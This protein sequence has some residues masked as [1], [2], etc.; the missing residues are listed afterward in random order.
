MQHLQS[1]NPQLALALGKVQE[2]ELRRAGQQAQAEQKVLE[3]LHTTV[4]EAPLDKIFPQ[5]KVQDAR[6]LLRFSPEEAKRLEQAL[7]GR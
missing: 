7:H 2:K 4:E 1:F 3:A 5:P 6:I